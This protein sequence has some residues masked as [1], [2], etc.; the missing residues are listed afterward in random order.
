VKAYR[1][2][3]YAG[4]VV[5][6]KARQTGTLVGVYHNGQSGVDSDVPWSTVCEEHGTVLTHPSL[7]LAHSHASDP[8][9]WCEMCRESLDHDLD[10][11]AKPAEPKGV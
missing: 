4:C 9:G 5:R 7:R 1:F 10:V 6:R 11:M 8:L 2:E 3:G